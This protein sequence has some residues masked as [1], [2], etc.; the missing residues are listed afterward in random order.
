MRMSVETLAQSTEG[1]RDAAAGMGAV[2]SASSSLA[3]DG[4]I[5]NSLSLSRRLPFRYFASSSADSG[6]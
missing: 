2:V 5:E 4:G 6:S 3:R 1:T